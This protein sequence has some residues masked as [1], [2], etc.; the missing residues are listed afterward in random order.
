MPDKVYTLT[1]EGYKQLEKKLKNLRTSE[2]AE[3]A[4]RIRQAKEFG[5]LDENAEYENAK[6]EQAKLEQEIAKL[7]KILRS[8]K[9]IEKKDEAE[10][11]DLG[12]RITV[13][14]VEEGKS[15][16]LEIVGTHESDPFHSPPR[17][18]DESPI[19]TAV[20]GKKPG[21]VVEAEI[22]LGTVHY[23]IVDIVNLD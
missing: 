6:A 22:P 20:M 3:I 16:Q 2:R 5:Q 19:G 10:E 4:E 9:I 21:D 1:K 13:E 8:A 14:Y 7:E 15:L 17:I 12:T 11:V 23:K 18:S